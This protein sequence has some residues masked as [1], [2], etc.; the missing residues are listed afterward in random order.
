MQLKLRKT[1]NSLSTTW[2]KELLARLNVKGR[3]SALRDRDPARR[4]AHTLR[5]G[6]RAHHAERRPGDRALQARLQGARRP[7]SE[8]VW[9]TD[10]EA[11][12]LNQRLIALFG[13]LEGGARD[14]HLLQAA[15][16]RPLNKWHYDDP[17]PDLF[18]L[19]GSVRLR[20]RAGAR[21]SRR[22]QAH[23]PCTGRR[24]PGQ[25]RLRPCG[26]GGR[27]D[28]G[29]GGSGRRLA[30][31]SGARR[32]V[33]AELRMSVASTHELTT[34]PSTGDLARCWIDASWRATP[35]P[36]SFPIDR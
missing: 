9:I 12:A 15:L 32:L 17:R 1:G 18:D 19:G 4:P 31:Q 14:A 27:G 8:P 33:A 21:V 34:L 30:V 3:R 22:Q 5:P 28:R 11:V 20:D 24:F 13:G 2:P 25:Q 29:D 35:A 23:G 7:V 6:V 16:A 10:R 26:G 36:L